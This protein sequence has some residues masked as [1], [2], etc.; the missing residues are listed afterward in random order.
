MPTIKRLRWISAA[1]WLFSWRIVYLEV[2]RWQHMTKTLRF[3][4]PPAPP[5]L[6]VVPKAG[7][8][9]KAVCVCAIAAP[10]VFLSTCVRPVT[11]RL[12]KSGVGPP[13]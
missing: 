2:F 11:A 8:P 12:S 1:A 10:A 9:L 7:L 13:R 6:N 4:P 3:N 5:G